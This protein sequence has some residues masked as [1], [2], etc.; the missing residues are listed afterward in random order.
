VVIFPG[1][2][3]RAGI[4]FAPPSEGPLVAP[5]AAPQSLGE[6][7]AQQRRFD[8]PPAQAQSVPARNPEETERALRSAL[9]TLQRM[10]GAA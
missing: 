3:M 8:A 2:A 5:A 10:S 1:Q 7:P 6:V 4:R 9:S